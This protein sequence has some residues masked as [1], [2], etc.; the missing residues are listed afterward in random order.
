MSHRTSSG[1][2]RQAGFSMVELLMAAFVMAIGIL[3]LT[4]LQAMSVRAGAGSKSLT[5]ALMVAEQVMD[6]IESNGR[7]SLLFV[8]SQPSST[9]PTWMT[10]SFTTASVSPPAVPSLT[11]NHAG[12]LNT[13]DPIDANPYFSV[14]IQPDTDASHSGIITP[15]PGLGGVANVQI[16]V[17]WVEDAAAGPRQVLLS[18]RIAYATS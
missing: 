14:Y 5:T 8:Q 4:M 13:G 1:R 7:N 2:V 6:Q 3:G 18:R 16:V 15:A 12:R 11:Y 10:S 9:P 17:Q